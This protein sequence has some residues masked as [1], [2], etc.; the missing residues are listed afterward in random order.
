PGRDFFR[1]RAFRVLRRVGAIGKAPKLEYDIREPQELRSRVFGAMRELLTR[2]ADR[3]PLLLVIDDLQ[4]ADADSM[5]LLKEIFRPPD[6][7]ALLLL[8]TL[9]STGDEVV[10]SLPQPTGRIVLDPLPPAE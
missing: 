4:W 5:A 1:A 9:R 3:H 2:L 7:P 6:P 10:R 8:A